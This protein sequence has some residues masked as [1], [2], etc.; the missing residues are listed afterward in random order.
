MGKVADANLPAERKQELEAMVVENMRTIDEAYGDN[1]PYNAERLVGEVKFYLASG[2]MAMLQAG[3][4]LILLKEH[5]PHGNFIKCVEKTGISHVLAKKM[6]LAARK[7]LDK[8]GRPN[9]E[10]FIHLN[11]VSKI[12]ELA[13]LD[14]EDIEALQEGGSLAGKTL[15]DIDKMTV[16]ELKEHI[17]GIKDE[18][19][20]EREAQA[21]ILSKKNQRIDELQ[22]KLHK[23]NFPYSWEPEA[24]LISAEI[25]TIWMTG[26][27]FCDRLTMV[28]GRIREVRDE[29]WNG[30]QRHLFDKLSRLMQEVGNAVDDAM[31]NLQ[32]GYI[33]NKLSMQFEDTK[34][35][36]AMLREEF[37]ERLPPI[38]G[39]SEPIDPIEGPKGA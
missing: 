39:E 10:T 26:T 32:A 12:Y 37:A 9:G 38:E 4:C 29:D 15:D 21:E 13:M 11:S 33:P 25:D 22:E 3:R 36:A 28:M 35:R 24:N 31:W 23:K 30:A 8:D 18:R 16:R 27:T 20:A 5:E 17:R 7:F 6:M 2:A 19:R 1:L 34:A 14:D